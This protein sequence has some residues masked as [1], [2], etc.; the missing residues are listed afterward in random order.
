MRLILEEFGPDIKHIKGTENIV[1]DAISRLPTTNKDQKEQCTKAYDLLSETLKETEQIIFEEEESFP[2]NLSLVRWTQQQELNASNS[3]LKQ[4]VNEKSAGY[5]ITTL[6]NIE[7]VTYE[8]KIYVPQKLR[9]KTME[10]YHHFLNHPG[11]D[12]LYKT[13]QKI[14]YWKGMASQCTSLCKTCKECQRHKPR[15]RKYG[16]LKNPQSNS[17]VERIHQVLR[18]M[19]LTKKL[20]NQIFDFIDPFGEILASIACAVRASHNSLIDATSVQLV[21]GQDMMF[22]LTTLV[23]WKALYLKKTESCRSSQST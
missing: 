18:H 5:K 3:K 6:D 10:W 20:Q 16:H 14:C 22:N 12:R 2:L 13:L 9:K 21:F 8:D 15:Q 17:P 11:S 4:T 1:S 7:I 19:F 23:N